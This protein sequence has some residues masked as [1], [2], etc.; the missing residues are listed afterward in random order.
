MGNFKIIFKW[1]ILKL[2]FS[3]YLSCTPRSAVVAS[4]MLPPV[5]LSIFLANIFCCHMLPLTTRQVFVT[6]YEYRMWP[7]F[8]YHLKRLIDSKFIWTQFS[9]I[10]LVPKPYLFCRHSF[11]AYRWLIPSL[12]GRKWVNLCIWIPSLPHG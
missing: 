9:F 1:H 2:K 8:K 4:L 10:V 7:E 6:L 11:G 5:S 12:E 3:E